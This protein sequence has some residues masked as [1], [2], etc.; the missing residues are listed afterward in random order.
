MPDSPSG[1]PNVTGSIPV[2]F[3]TG[4]NTG[5]TITISGDIHNHAQPDQ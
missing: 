5:V 1:T 2:A 3:I 4:S